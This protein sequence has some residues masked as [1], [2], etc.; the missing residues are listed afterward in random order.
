[1][2]L[3]AIERTGLPFAR[4][5][6][7]GGKLPSAGSGRS[8]TMFPS[9]DI[10]SQPIG[11]LH[12]NHRRLPVTIFDEV[13]EISAQ[14]SRAFPRQNPSDDPE[15]RVTVLVSDDEFDAIS[16]EARCGNPDVSIENNF[17]IVRNVRWLPRS[18]ARADFE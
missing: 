13:L 6:R 9:I 15:S 7:G 18:S 10:L 14:L 2:E 5:K 1:M 3:R 4:A 16:V 11:R 8:Y 12:L 17:V